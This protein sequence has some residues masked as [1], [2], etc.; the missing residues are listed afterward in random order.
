MA[1]TAMHSSPAVMQHISHRLLTT[2]LSRAQVAVAEAHFSR[3]PV[4]VGVQA[5]AMQRHYV[6]L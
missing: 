4:G 2:E 3:K 6:A 5:G 1:L